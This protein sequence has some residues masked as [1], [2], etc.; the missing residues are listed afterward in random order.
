VTG[1]AGPPTTKRLFV[2]CTPRLIPRLIHMMIHRLIPR[3]FR[4][5][6]KGLE[7][8][9]IPLEVDCTKF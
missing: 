9:P 3:L 8:G 2:L 7:A 1:L 5:K 6:N 4:T